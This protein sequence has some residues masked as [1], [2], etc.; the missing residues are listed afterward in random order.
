MLKLF[1]DDRSFHCLKV[2][3][4]S[5]S[6]SRVV[7]EGS[8]RLEFFGSNVVISCTESEARSLLFYAEHCPGVVAAIQEALRSADWPRK[9]P[10]RK[11]IRKRRQDNVTRK[12]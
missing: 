10:A 2:S 4:P 5:G 9:N 3:V 11:P 8:V 6:R 7:V 1:L 12:T